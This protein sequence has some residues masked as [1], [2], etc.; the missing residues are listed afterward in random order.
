MAHASSRLPRED[1]DDVVEDSEREDEGL[2]SLAFTLKA[3]R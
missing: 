1:P 2:S 3:R